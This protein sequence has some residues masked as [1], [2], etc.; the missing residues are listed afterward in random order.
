MYTLQKWQVIKCKKFSKRNEA[1]D[2]RKVLIQFHLFNQNFFPF[3]NRIRFGV[4]VVVVV[5]LLLITLC[6][7]IVADHCFFVLQSLHRK[8]ALFL[9][10]A[11]KTVAFSPTYRIGIFLF[12]LT[13]LLFKISLGSG[14]HLPSVAV[15]QFFNRNLSNKR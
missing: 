4:V 11:T 3:E 15:S 2:N 12:I 1:K 14:N 10:M 8:H 13:L 6:N 9:L 7:I 5:V